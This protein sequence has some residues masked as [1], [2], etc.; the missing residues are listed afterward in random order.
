[1]SK[2]KFTGNVEELRKIIAENI[3][4][5]SKEE[6]FEFLE[7]IENNHIEEIDK[8][9]REIVGLEEEVTD[10]KNQTIDGDAFVEVDIGVGRFVYMDQYMNL[11]FQDK[12]EQ[13]IEDFKNGCKRV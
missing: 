11:L 4:F 8:L 3:W 10:L 13:F 6:A 1:M 7:A 5:G 9:K 12:L 2:D